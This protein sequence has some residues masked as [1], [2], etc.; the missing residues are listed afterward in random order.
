MNPSADFYTGNLIDITYTRTD[1]FTQTLH[2]NVATIPQ[3]VASRKT[4][5]KETRVP[6][7]SCEVWMRNLDTNR[8]SAHV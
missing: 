7:N 4:R 2:R 1:H 8:T 3:M 6:A 5:V